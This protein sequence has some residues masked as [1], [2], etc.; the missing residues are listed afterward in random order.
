MRLKQFQ[1]FISDLF[2]HV[3]RALILTRS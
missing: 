1:F 2:H 3:R